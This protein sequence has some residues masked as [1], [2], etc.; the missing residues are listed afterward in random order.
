MAY[1]IEF[2]GGDKVRDK[3]DSVKKTWRIKSIQAYQDTEMVTLSEVGNDN[4]VRRVKANDLF[5]Y[6]EMVAKAIRAPSVA[7]K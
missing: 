3:R 5:P 2:Q 7:Q 6:L 4:N 1:Q